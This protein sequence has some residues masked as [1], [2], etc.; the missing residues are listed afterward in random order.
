MNF[1]EIRQTMT[2]DACDIVSALS[3]A[4]VLTLQAIIFM[5]GA[6]EHTTRFI[7]EQMAALDV[8]SE[9]NDL[10]RLTNGFK[11]SVPQGFG[12]SC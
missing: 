6:K 11:A 3:Q 4:K 5:T 10:W 12:D 2:D 1:T 9:D 7:L 8:A